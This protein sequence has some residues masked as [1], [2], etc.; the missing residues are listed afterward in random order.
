MKEG[1]PVDKVE[2]GWGWTFV[3][4]ILNQLDWIRAGRIGQCMQGSM[5]TAVWEGH[6]GQCGQSAIDSPQGVWMEEYGQAM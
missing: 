3:L 6:S 4:G 2:P 5:D 1:V